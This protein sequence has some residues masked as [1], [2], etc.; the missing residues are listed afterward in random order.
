MR[1]CQCKRCGECVVLYPSGC[2]EAWKRLESKRWRREGRFSLKEIQ[3]SKSSETNGRLQAASVDHHTRADATLLWKSSPVPGIALR[4][5]QPI[6]H[7]L[8]VRL[9]L[10]PWDHSPLTLRCVCHA[11]ARILRTPWQLPPTSPAQVMASAFVPSPHPFPVL[12]CSLCSPTSRVKSASRTKV[13]TRSGDRECAAR[14][15]MWRSMEHFACLR[16]RRRMR[17]RSKRASPARLCPTELAAG[18]ARELLT[19][20]FH[21]PGLPRRPRERERKRA[22]MEAGEGEKRGEILGCPAEGGPAQGGE[23]V[24]NGTHGSTPPS[25][26]SP[27]G[28]GPFLFFLSFFFCLFFFLSCLFFGV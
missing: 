21:G 9:S 26:P 24:Q 7:V 8:R 10:W 13:G 6:G 20:T 4:P 5:P 19:C 27:P 11:S 28:R 12:S 23:A 15:H 1:N 25:S 18:A 17:R 14:T 22:K 16:A 3:L 2:R